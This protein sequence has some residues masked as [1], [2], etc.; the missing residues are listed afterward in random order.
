MIRALA[1]AL[2]GLR[3]LRGE[4][5]GSAT[6]EFVILFTPF[7]IL[8]IS[9]FESGLMMTRHVMLERGLDMAVRA[10]RIGTVTPVTNNQLKTMICNGAGI[11][12]NCM[13]T[14]K[15]EM[16]RVDPRN[17][18]DVRTTADCIDVNNPAA[19]VLS[20]ENGTSNDIMVVRV[21]SLFRP[22]FPTTGL[23][24]QMP[25][26]SGDYYALVSTSAFVMEPV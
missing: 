23:G 7:M 18:T 4:E 8:F 24:F 6:V 10:V 16:T 25:R 15:V 17:W 19:P 14:I 26:K 2:R 12:P 11:I 22:I 20:F 5:N 3:R 13:T 21:C 1:L 9:A